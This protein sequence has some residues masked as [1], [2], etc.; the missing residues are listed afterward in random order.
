VS[1]LVRAKSGDALR[2][3]FQKPVVEPAAKAKGGKPV[4]DEDLQGDE[5]AA[6]AGP[7]KAERFGRV[8]AWYLG[9]DGREQLF[10]DS[11]DITFSAPTRELDIK[12][13]KDGLYL[14]T[15]KA[16]RGKALRSRVVDRPHVI[17]ADVRTRKSFQPLVHVPGKLE[18]GVKPNTLY[19]L[20][21]PAGTKNFSVQIDRLA[22]ARPITLEIGPASGRPALEVKA[23]R[24]TEWYVKVPAGAD[25]AVWRLWC[26][27]D[28]FKQLGLG[29][30]P[31]Y[32]AT[33]PRNLL[34]PR[35]E[36]GGKATTSKNPSKTNAK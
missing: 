28:T 26:D 13:E 30:I 12:A 21:V 34:V 15:V 8:E 24:D 16:P 18:P 33:D 35:D 22:S 27:A 3:A 10:V 36:A 11:L 20:Y 9:G 14:L 17:A 29:G 5:D 2:L 1:Y 4:A 7:A 23:S 32:V 31:P 6:K 19:Y 25:A